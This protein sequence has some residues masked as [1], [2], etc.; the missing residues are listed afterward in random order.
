M[1][2]LAFPNSSEFAITIDDQVIGW[3]EILAQ[4]QLFGKLR[5]FIQEIASQH[6][7][8]QEIQSNQDLKVQTSELEQTVIDFRLRNQL[9]DQ[10]QFQKWLAQEGMDYPAF[11]NR[12]VFGLK[13]KKLKAQVTEPN[14]LAA[15]EQRKP[16]LEQVE[17]SYLIV[18]ARDLAE[19]LAAQLQSGET[20]FEQIAQTHGFG[21]DAV[22]LTTQVLRRGWLT[23]EIQAALSTRQVGELVGPIALE[24]RWGILR[25]ERVLPV[26]LD[27]RL[28]RQLEEQLFR[29][30]LA[31]KINALTVRLSASQE[32]LSDLSEGSG[33]L[34][35]SNPA[36]FVGNGAGQEP[37]YAQLAASGA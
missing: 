36:E 22:K 11:Q 21:N 9:A 12:V 27:E 3:T 26:E 14:L 18:Q 16:T 4:L 25:I 33:L 30:W 31:E 20:S 2:N 37:D 29:Q 19:Q 24:E 23:Q 7:I 13:V 35:R 28:Q 6:L 5:P 10:E 17:L 15:F 34:D 1:N 8:I 32:P